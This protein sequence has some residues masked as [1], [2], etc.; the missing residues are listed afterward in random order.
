[1]GMPAAD[2]RPQRR[3]VRI[4]AD[5]GYFLL[6]ADVRGYLRVHGNGEV[7]AGKVKLRAV[8]AGHGDRIRLHPIRHGNSVDLAEDGVRLVVGC[9]D[10]LALSLYRL[11]FFFGQDGRQRDQVLVLETVAFAQRLEVALVAHVPGDA[12]DML[13]CPPG[14]SNLAH[15]LRRG[16]AVD[17]LCALSVGLLETLREALADDGK[18]L[19]FRQRVAVSLPVAPDGLLH[20]PEEVAVDPLLVVVLPYLLV[21]IRRH[22]DI[23]GVVQPGKQGLPQVLPLPGKRALFPVGKLV[24][25]VL[26]GVGSLVHKLRHRAFQPF[27]DDLCLARI[28]TFSKMLAQRHDLFVLLH[29]QLEPSVFFRHILIEQPLGPRCFSEDGI[30]IIVSLEEVTQPG[31]FLRPARRKP[32]PAADAVTLGKGAELLLVCPGILIF[33]L[34]MIPASHLASESVQLFAERHRLQHHGVQD[35]LPALGVRRFLDLAFRQ[36]LGS[37]GCLLCLCRRKAMHR[38]LGKRH[39]VQN[40]TRPCAIRLS[41]ARGAYLAPCLPG[42]RCSL[43]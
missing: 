20:E 42:K 40:A 24:A 21:A 35:S 23:L 4:V 19:Q 14:A 39:S 36:E 8:C 17:T 7:P 12:P 37:L 5:R 34:A 25:A 6:V 33:D 10:Q 11:P 27:G 3:E 1:M 30:F 32:V 9:T 13:R 15:G 38:C 31:Q 16:H 2:G 26:Q 18:L 43:D 28:H 29:G 22:E 41:V